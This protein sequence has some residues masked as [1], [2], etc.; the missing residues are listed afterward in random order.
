MDGVE[1]GRRWKN[2]G[3]EE[4][5]KKDDVVVMGDENGREKK[6]D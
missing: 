2:K 5:K 1:K 4:K 3:K 6:I